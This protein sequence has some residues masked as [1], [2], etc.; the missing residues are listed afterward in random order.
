MEVVETKQAVGLTLCQD[1]TEIVRG[2]RKGARFRKGHVVTKEDI[3]VLLALGKEHLYVWEENDQLLH[4]EAAAEL[5]YRLCDSEFIEPTPVKEGKIEAKAKVAGVVTVKTAALDQVNG[6][7]ETMIATK[8]NF[9]EAQK[10]ETIAG[11]RIIPLTIAKEK[12]QQLQTVVPEREL[13][14][15]WP[16]KTKTVGIVTTG[17]EVYKRRIKDGFEPVLREKLASYPVEI[18]AHQIVDDSLAHITAAIEDMKQAG[19]DIIL[20]TGGMSVDPDDVTADAIKA[21]SDE[22]VCYGTP[23]LPGSMFSLAYTKNGQTIMGLPGAVMFSEK[24]VFDLIWPRVLAEL[25]ITPQQIAQLGVGG[26]L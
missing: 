25:T 7:G 17:S 14:Q 22:L 13:V 16:F 4:E 9:Y 1:I 11:M 15:L 26:L 23:V 24:T 20:C 18:T 12:M 21:T 19:I 6:F 3:P 10:G 8:A 5:L 2:V